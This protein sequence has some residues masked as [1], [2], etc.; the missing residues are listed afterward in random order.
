MLFAFVQAAILTLPAL[1]QDSA[2]SSLAEAYEEV[3]QQRAVSEGGNIGTLGGEAGAQAI[4]T[5]AEYALE[6]DKATGISVPAFNCDDGV[7]VP[8]QGSVPRGPL[9]DH[10]NVLNGVCD[11]GSKFQVLPGST[12]DAVAV[13]H[14]RR[15]GQPVEGPF[16]NDVAVIQYNKANGAVCFYQ[17]LKRRHDPPQNALPANVPAPRDVGG[18]VWMPGS[19]A[20]WIDP[21]A[22]VVI[23]CTGCHNNGGFLRSNYLAQLKTPP[24]ALPS[25]DQGF[26]N[27]N[28]MLRFVGSA[29]QNDF[30][31][32]VEVPA[33]P[34]GQSC[35]LCHRLAVSS[36]EAFGKIN[37]TAP[38]FG[39][40]ATD[41][42][43][44]SKSPHS[45]QSPIWMKP[46]QVLFDPQSLNSAKKYQKCAVDFANSG[47]KTIGL[48]CKIA[49]LGVPFKN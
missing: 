4:Q 42:S 2:P 13:A 22:T 26:T 3:L 36:R 9:C 16:Y 1:S 8:G 39:V 25:T 7:A 43:Q 15:D 38:I 48:G 49:P 19:G 18:N 11:P 21:E 40:F 33:L 10:P 44:A 45:V 37:G 28:A 20:H 47:F 14:C 31:W 17:A 5:L 35:T 29:Y 46:G 12:A 30:T 27:K 32:S 24:H 6:C 41:V 34:A 23:G